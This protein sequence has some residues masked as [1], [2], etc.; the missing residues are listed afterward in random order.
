MSSS[1]DLALTLDAALAMIQ[2]LIDCDDFQDI[3]TVQ[4]M[5]HVASTNN[6]DNYY[7]CFRFGVHKHTFK[8]LSIQNITNLYAAVTIY[9]L[10]SNPTFLTDQEV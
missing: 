1:R 10:R 2:I 9:L 3:A 7:K 5:F 6:Y 4:V 8:V